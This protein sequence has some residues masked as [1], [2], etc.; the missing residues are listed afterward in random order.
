MGRKVRK[1]GV[2]QREAPSLVLAVDA[3]ATHTRA[4]I[5]DI[6]GKVLGKGFAGPAN[7]Y[8]VGAALANQNLVAAI[9]QALKKSGV[10]RKQISV[11]AIGSASVDYDDS[12]AA[13]I[14]KS[15]RQQLSS[16]SV[17]VKADALIAL[18]GALGGKPG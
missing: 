5:A 1:G 17:L 7:S 11:A 2:L 4:A 8:A 18:E 13:P 16:A 6:S 15:L 3:G 9:S 14:A 12:G 10:D